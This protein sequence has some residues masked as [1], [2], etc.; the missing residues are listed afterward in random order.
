MH[1]SYSK[2]LSIGLST[3]SSAL[4]FKM[5]MILSLYSALV[6][7]KEKAIVES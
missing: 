3:F 7:V 2:N 6:T 1:C 4:T 5:K